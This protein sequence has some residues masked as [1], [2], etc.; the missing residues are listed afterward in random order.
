MKD[1]YPIRIISMKCCAIFILCAIFLN[2]SCA[3]SNEARAYTEDFSNLYVLNILPGVFPKNKRYAVYS[4]PNEDYLRGA[5]GKAVVSTN[6]PVQILGRE[7][8]WILIQY[9]IDDNHHRIGW[10][11]DNAIQFDIWV[12]ELPSPYCTATLKKNA[13]I[14]DDPFYSEAPLLSFPTDIEVNVLARLSDWIYIES[15]SEA[16]FRG[17]VR[18][19]QLTPGIVFDSASW[20]HSDHTGTILADISAYYWPILDNGYA[21]NGISSD[22]AIGTVLDKG[23]KVN[24]LE[25]E[26]DWV[27]ISNSIGGEAFGPYYIPSEYILIAKDESSF[28]ERSVAN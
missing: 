26:G 19:D 4:G 8:G 22:E 16:S 27:K 24:V 10:I 23:L 15:T 7:N 1:A 13:L 21:A 5:N 9:A 12:S 20:P 28:N 11:Y 2:I 17:F 3:K 6:A 25:I 18:D 14:T